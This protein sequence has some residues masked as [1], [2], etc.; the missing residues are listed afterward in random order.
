MGI[1]LSNKLSGLHNIS[2]IFLGDGAIEEGV[3]YEAANFA[4]VKKLPVIFVCENNMYSVY[5]SLDVRQPQKRSISNMV[6]GIGVR[7]T[8]LDSSNFQDCITKVIEAI[9]RIRRGDG[10]EFLEISA[11][12]WREHCGPNYDN[13]IGYRTIDEFEAFKLK[14][15]KELLEATLLRDSLINP[16]YIE[17][18]L[19][20]IRKEISVA[21]EF[22]KQS[23]F[24]LPTDCVNDEY[25]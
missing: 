19:K 8:A 24:P 16:K 7:S 2:C 21:F 12:R 5:S 15:P 14:D 25:A 11:Y 9:Q 10:P 13:D 4:A 18:S 6:N 3:F 1:A 23:P 17:E 20:N 22:A